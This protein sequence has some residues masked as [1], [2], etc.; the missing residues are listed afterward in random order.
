MDRRSI[1]F[2]GASAAYTVHPYR[3]RMSKEEWICR[4]SAR[5]HAQWPSVSRQ[6][7]DETAAELW[8]N[9]RWRGREP[10]EAAVEWVRQGIPHAH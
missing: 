8:V 9:D 10:E 1:S 3:C 5:L 7:R 6:Q 4:C 2:F